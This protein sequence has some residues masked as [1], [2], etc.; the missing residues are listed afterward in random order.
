VLNDPAATAVSTMSLD[1]FEAAELAAQS[2]ANTEPELRETTI[3]EMASML[4]VLLFIASSSLEAL[5]RF[6]TP[7]TI[8]VC[9]PYV[10][11]IIWTL[12]DFYPSNLFSGDFW[13]VSPPQTP[14]HPGLESGSWE[15]GRR[16]DVG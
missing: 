8:Q 14:P 15:A 16:G 12:L 1:D 11:D 9:L 4:A 13:G 7:E 10:K 5:V 2:P 3:A 6:V